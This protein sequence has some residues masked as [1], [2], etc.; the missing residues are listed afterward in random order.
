[1]VIDFYPF[2]FKLKQIFFM[3]VT[4]IGINYFYI[5]TRVGLILYQ[6]HHD[7]NLIY[8]AVAHG[9]SHLTLVLLLLSFHQ[10]AVRRLQITLPMFYSSFILFN[11]RQMIVTLQGCD[12]LRCVN[13]S[14]DN[15]HYF[16]LQKLLCTTCLLNTDKHLSDT[17]IIDY[18]PH[19][20]HC[21]FFDKSYTINCDLNHTCGKGYL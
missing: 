3:S 2:I 1:M 21:K 6:V 12:T 11:V 9:Q 5:F 10:H 20:T 17:D 19:G 13:F 4:L 16:K 8:I 18:F 14:F 7:L 15:E